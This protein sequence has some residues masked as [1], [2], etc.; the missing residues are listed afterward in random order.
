MKDSF[1]GRRWKGETKK[2]WKMP[3]KVIKKLRRAGSHQ[4]TKPENK[5]NFPL[6]PSSFQ[7]SVLSTSALGV[8]PYNTRFSSHGV[9]SYSCIPYFF[10][11]SLHTPM[12][13]S[14]FISSFLLA[15]LLLL[16]L[17]SVCLILIF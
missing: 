8:A 13:S 1:Q 17:H 6:S 12:L 7:S 15:H 9:S 5:L 11:P 10:S 4:D 16:F 3:E 14:S 2:D